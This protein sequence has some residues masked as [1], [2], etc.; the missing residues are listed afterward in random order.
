[1]EVSVSSGFRQVA[2][3]FRCERH[4][5]GM[6]AVGGEKVGPRTHPAGFHQRV[7]REVLPA[8]ADDGDR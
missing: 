5:R 2:L 6:S 7:D 3:V 8:L 1:M 4:N